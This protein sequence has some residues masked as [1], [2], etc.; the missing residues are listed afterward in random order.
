M[1]NN[2]NKT[3]QINERLDFVNLDAEQRTALAGMQ[4]LIGRSLGGALDKF[5]AKAKAVP[6][7]GRMF[8][9]EAHV[10]HAK[11]RQIKH[12]EMI[13]S[14]RFDATYVDAVT[15]IGRTHA[16][17]G[18]E[19]RW[20]IGGYA[21]IIEELFNA[22]LLDELKGFIVGK[23]AAKL[24][25][26]MA[27]IMKAAMVDMDYSISTYL[28][29]LAE[30]RAKAEA[31]R[32]ALQEDQRVAQVA[33]ARAL[34]ALA[35]GDLTAS[36]TAELSPQFAS[37]KSNYNAAVVR[38]GEALGEVRTAV[39]QMS[40]GVAE[41]SSA[42]DDMARRTE[43]QAAALE[44]TAA[45]LEQITT[46]A[47]QASTRTRQ[48]QALSKASADEAGKSSEVVRDA[49]ASMAAIEDSSRQITAIISVIDEIS[50][51]TNLLA[52]NAGVEAARAGEAGKGFAVVAQE[53]RE[54]AQRSARAAKEIEA[55][56]GK[57]S[58]DVA[59]GVSLVN[60]A[61]EALQSIGL[62]ISDIN[63]DIDGIAQSAQEQATGIREINTAV[64]NLDYIT[65]QNAAMMEETNASTAALSE[66]SVRLSSLVERFRTPGP[67]RNSDGIAGSGAAKVRRV[68]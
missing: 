51:Q 34:E 57:S 17:L 36:I 64:A 47:G 35:S 37:L 65:Q 6:E 42:S 52:L 41:M 28:D 12:W 46:V 16:R 67:Y 45:A 60:A 30:E 53:V 49:I 20:Y 61:G 15:A 2:D 68:L 27:A 18:L 40:S 39:N 19:P 26:R 7:T 21:L 59:R 66:I 56:I 24:S 50:F 54:L 22:V 63:E 13:A 48:A 23:R 3:R 29:A 33:I 58:S 62:R 43:Q 4:P 1:E 9:N 44:E 10:E 32:A 55:L 31:E 11:E 25:R 14:A 38:L 5:Y 8:A